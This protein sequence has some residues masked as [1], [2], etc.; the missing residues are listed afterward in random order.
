MGHYTPS[1]RFK[2]LDDFE[3]YIEFADARFD[4]PVLR[5]KRYHVTRHLSNV[6]FRICMAYFSL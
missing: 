3:R 5:C 2:S 1:C 6:E 4:G